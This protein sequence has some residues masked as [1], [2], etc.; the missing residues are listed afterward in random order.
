M[1]TVSMHIMSVASLCA[2]YHDAG[3]ES[4]LVKDLPLHIRPVSKVDHTHSALCHLCGALVKIT[5]MRNHVGEH[6]LKRDRRV[7]EART[8]LKQVSLHVQYAD[9]R[10]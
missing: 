8:L 5:S 6:I 10:C 2:E 1:Q 3:V 4:L 9:R 7:P